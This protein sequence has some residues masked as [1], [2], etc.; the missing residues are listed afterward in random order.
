MVA[1]PKKT[2]L[3]SGETLVTF[4]LDRTGSMQSIKDDTI[5]AFNAYLEG[6]QKDPAGISFTLVQF[7][8]MSLDKVCVGVPVRDAPPL[9]DG[10]YQR[11]ASTPLIDAAYKTIK[12]VEKSA[13]DAKTKIVICIQT[14]GQENCSTEHTWAELH[15]LIKEK[16]AANWQFNFMGAGIDAYEQGQR[17]GI[18]AAATMSY[19]SSD[20]R[21]TRAAFAASASNTQSFRHGLSETTQYSA[22]QRSAS[23]DRFAHRVSDL[24][25]DQ[26]PASVAPTGAAKKPPAAKKPLVDDFTL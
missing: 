15:A 4:L 2:K 3:E 23:G 12:A 18:S 10:N 14:D 26:S 20:R 21:A 22:A 24:Q 17:M 1:K 6:L 11:R 16:A 19:D 7:D 13:P 8:S 5:G 25:S 9:S